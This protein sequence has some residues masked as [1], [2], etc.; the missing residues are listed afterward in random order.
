MEQVYSCPRCYIPCTSRPADEMAVAPP[1]I[2]IPRS[3]VILLIVFTLQTNR[4]FSH[5]FPLC[6]FV[7]SFRHI[8]VVKT[9]RAAT[10]ARPPTVFRVPVSPRSVVRGRH[11]LPVT[12]AAQSTPFRK[13]IVLGKKNENEKAASTHVN[14]FIFSVCSCVLRS[15]SHAV[16]P[17]RKLR[18]RLR[19][20]G[21]V[22]V[23]I[24]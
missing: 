21:N 5:R 2:K 22:I 10:A 8:F 4:Q 19:P 6:V 12:L 14:G 7:R 3:W 23:Q 1:V 20:E 9:T 24:L 11:F 18:A 16:K 15:I 17:L 13:H